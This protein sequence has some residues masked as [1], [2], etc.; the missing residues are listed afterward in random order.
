M[1]EEYPINCYSRQTMLSEIGVEGQRK[2]VSACV[3]I[4]G[5]GGLGT[6]I[7]LYLAGAGI[8]HIGLVDDDVVSVSNLHRQVLYEES[9]VGRLKVDAA[10]RRLRA[11]NSQV[12]V[13]SYPYRL[14]EQNAE[15]LI[16][17]YDVVLDGCDNFATRFLINDI[18]QLQGKPYVYGAIQGFC[19]QVSVFTGRQGAKSYRDL[20]PDEHAT[21]SLPPQ[22]QGVVGMTPAIVGSVQAHEAMKLIC[23][24]GEV[25]DGKLWTIDL[26]TLQSYVLDI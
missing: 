20:F 19:G 22:H 24:Y 4:V 10:A 1:K 11:L 26:R 18:C 13:T 12:T 14:N 9:Q 16:N 2:L 15:Q 3:L 8:G 5:V 23:G 17:D 6:P 21:L 7:S 25:L